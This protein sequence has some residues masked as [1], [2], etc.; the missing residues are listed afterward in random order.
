MIKHVASLLACI[1]PTKCALAAP[2]D[3][4][5]Q[6][7]KQLDTELFAAFN[8]C[9]ID[10][11]ASMYS[12]Q[13]EFYHDTAGL[14]NYAQSI[15]ASKT[16]CAKKLGLTRTLIPESLTVYPI[17]DF[18]A[19]QMGE[20]RFC[21]LVNGKNDCGTFRFTHIWRHNKAGWKLHRVISYGH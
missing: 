16:L 21:H 10:A 17:K 9:D 2:N 15:A 20:H 11:L 14:D 19:L 6:Q 13:L 3:S 12:K 18:G 4:L 7:I 1:L 8:R 5:Y